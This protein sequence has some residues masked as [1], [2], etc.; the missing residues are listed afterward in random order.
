[1]FSINDTKFIHKSVLHSFLLSDGRVIKHFEKNGKIHFD[2]SFFPDDSIMT[3]KYIESFYNVYGIRP[4]IYEKSLK[5]LGCIEVRCFSRKIFDD[6]KKFGIYGTYDWRIPSKVF[7]NNEAL[8][9]WIKCFF[10]S[11]AYVSNSCKNI[12]VKSV[13][14]FGLDDISNTLKSFD[15]ESKIYG[16]Y[17]QKVKTQSDY[18]VLVVSR[19]TNV[20]KY[21]NTIGFYHSKKNKDLDIIC[22]GRLAR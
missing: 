8:R 1:M 15:I 12:Q 6:V 11:E 4:K 16:P 17:K 10:T 2:V 14:K 18:F 13:N 20:L 7:D 3:N 19:K 5:T 21:R 9:E 22:R